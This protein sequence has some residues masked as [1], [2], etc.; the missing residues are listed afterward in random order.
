MNDLT[1]ELQGEMGLGLSSPSEPSSLWLQPFA[2]LFRKYRIWPCMGGHTPGSR[3]VLVTA[4]HCL[5]W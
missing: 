3:C 5:D 2:A 4:E 1:G